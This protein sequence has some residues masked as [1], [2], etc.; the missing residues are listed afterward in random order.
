MKATLLIVLVAL[1][2]GSCRVFYR[3]LLG[4]DSTP[5]WVDKKYLE[6]RSRQLGLPDSQLFQ[7]DTMSLTDAFTKPYLDLKES[8]L[9]D[10][11]LS[12]ADSL[13]LKKEAKKLKNKLQPVQALYFNKNGAPIYWMINCYVDPV[14]PRMNWNIDSSFNFFPPRPF[15]PLNDSLTDSLSFFLPHIRKADN[16]VLTM[17]DLPEADYY[18]LILW[19]DILKRPSRKLIELVQEYH[20]TYPDKK[21]HVLYVNNLNAYLWPLMPHEQKE[22]ALKGN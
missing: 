9:S 16:S 15:S 6:K 1:L 17:R 22:E 14:F 8:L 3:V 10:S 19:N 11:L 12:S 4:I 7:L 13:L 2:F 21:V 18:V 5:G 20:K